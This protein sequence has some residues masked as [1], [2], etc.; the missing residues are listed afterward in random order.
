MGEGASNS[1]MLPITAPS[2]T[3]MPM[4]EPSASLHFSTS[5]F[6]QPSGTCTSDDEAS[7]PTY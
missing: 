7:V 1:I 6:T 2:G 3:L 5:P 4:V